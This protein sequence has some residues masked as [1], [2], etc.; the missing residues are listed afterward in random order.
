MIHCDKRALRRGKSCSD[1]HVERHALMVRT[2]RDRGLKKQIYKARVNGQVRKSLRR[3]TYHDQIED[4]PKK[5]QVKSILNR[6]ACIKAIMRID[7]AKHVCHDRNKWK[8]VVSAYPNGIMAWS[9]CIVFVHNF[10]HLQ[11]ASKY[12]IYA[13]YL[14]LWWCEIDSDYVRP[15]INFIFQILCK[16]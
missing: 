4:V 5:G 10:I 14:N 9:V 1:E 6:Q 8:A 7:Y 15:C 11:S 13:L 12:F 2:C 16:I 3:Q